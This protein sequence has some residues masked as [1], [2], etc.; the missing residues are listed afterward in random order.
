MDLGGNG[1]GKRNREK[2]KGGRRKKGRERFV[3]FHYK[4]HRS[5]EAS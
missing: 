4:Y 3:M 5:Q 2:K 1:K